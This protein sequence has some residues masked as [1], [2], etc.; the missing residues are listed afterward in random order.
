MVIVDNG[1]VYGDSLI[2][3]VIWWP[4]FV[5]GLN[6]AGINWNGIPVW[7]FMLDKTLIKSLLFTI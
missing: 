3:I 2:D 7:K 5:Q 1:Y 4:E 6:R